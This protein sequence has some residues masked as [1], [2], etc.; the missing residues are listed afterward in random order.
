MSPLPHQNERG[1]AIMVDVGSKDETARQAEACGRINLR[2][3][4]LAALQQG[5]VTKGDAFSVAR[6][7][8]I[9]AVKRTAELIPLC[10]PLPIDAVEIAITPDS[11]GV[12][13]SVTV[14]THGRTGVEMEALTG[15]SIGLLALYDMVKS[16]D[17]DARIEA[18]E[19]RSKSGGRSGAWARS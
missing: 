15:V 12:S 19:L 1:E 17:R 18:I 7:A 11:L 9:Q 8:A 5:S 6:I 16:I 2:P 14:R 4:T 13:L 10:H 3:E